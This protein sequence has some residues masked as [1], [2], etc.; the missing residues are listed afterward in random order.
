MNRANALKVFES[1]SL[2]VDFVKQE[3]QS[4]VSVSHPNIVRVYGWGRLPQSGRLYLLSEFLEGEE[5]TVYTR[6]DQRLSVRVDPSAKVP[7]AGG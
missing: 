6:P 4:L 7:H 2:S 3:A 5:L 1:T